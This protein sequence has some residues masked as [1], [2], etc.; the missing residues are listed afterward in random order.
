MPEKIS[1]VGLAD[2]PALNKLINSAYRGEESKKGW[3]TEAD[4]LDGTRIDEAALRDIIQKP[5]TTFLKYE[6]DGTILG[7]VELRKEENKLYLGT[8]SVN[9]N[10]QNKGIGKKLLQAGEEHAKQIGCS[11]MRMTVI[12][13]RQSLIDWYVRHGYQLTGERKPFVVPDDRWGIPKQKLEFV[14]LEKSL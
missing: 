1:K 4:L 14:V 10:I 12:D 2:V 11:R 3:S 13:G 6:E 8:L 7:C 5:D 9:P